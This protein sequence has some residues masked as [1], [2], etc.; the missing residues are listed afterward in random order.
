MTDYSA[1]S[2][3]TPGFTGYTGY[4]GPG[5]STSIGLILTA[6]GSNVDASFPSMRTRTAMVLLNSNTRFL[7]VNGSTFTTLQY[8]TLIGTSAVLAG[9][10]TATRSGQPAN[11]MVACRVSISGTDYMVG[12]NDAASTL[13]RWDSDGQNRA[14]MSFSGTA[15]TN[16]SRIGWD[17]TNGYLLI[18]DS[19]NKAGTTIR[20]YT[21][22]G[23]TATNIASNL[24]LSAAPANAGMATMYIG[25]T[26]IVME[27]SGSGNCTWQRYDLTGTKVD[28]ITGL[29]GANTNGFAIDVVGNKMY[30]CTLG[31]ST[32]V[33]FVLFDI[34]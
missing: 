28:T 7:N 23:T 5:T 1:F 27:D 6:E 30:L 24:T 2:Q 12:A 33:Y 10:N 19:A 3:A 17:V 31:S 14:T 34:G 9:Y 32:M 22:S 4:T 18:M 16:I 11:V 29:G 26:Y 13:Y 15:P 20:R 25:A 8:K 21:L